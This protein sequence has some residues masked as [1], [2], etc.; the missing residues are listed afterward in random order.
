VSPRVR[1]LALVSVT[2]AVAVAVVVG[3]TLLQ[4]DEPR[5]AAPA[6]PQGDPPLVLDLGLRRD[7]EA[8]DLR[9]AERLYD[10]G[11]SE[12][13]ARIFGRYRSL[14]ARIGLALARW[15]RH[16][17]TRLEQLAAEEPRSGLVRLNLGFALFWSGRREAAV[18]TWRE[19]RRVDPD[20]IAAVRAGDLLY[21]SFARGLPV[22]VPSPGASPRLLAGVRLQR[23]GKQLSARREYD[24]AVRLDPDDPEALVAA[25]VARFDKADPSKAFAR[26]GP[27]ARRFPREPTVRFHLGLLLLWMGQVDAAKEQLA[28]A[29]ATD[30]DAPLAREADRFLRRLEDIGTS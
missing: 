28:K 18:A 11:R 13:A 20:S 24:A 8:R 14:D 22:F 7:A 9:R 3:A 21:P 17:V 6:R 12:E 4:S 27:L 30:R 2:A 29:R 15:P 23:V 5:S 16:T 25:A 1:I 26:L 10:R 19:T